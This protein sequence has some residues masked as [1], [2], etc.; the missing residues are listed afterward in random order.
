MEMNAID[1]VWIYIPK[2]SGLASIERLHRHSVRF[3]KVQFAAFLALLYF[4]LLNKKKFFIY[5]YYKFILLVSI[6]SHT[7]S[8]GPKFGLTRGLTAQNLVSQKW[9]HGQTFSSAFRNFFLVF[10]NDLFFVPFEECFPLINLLL[11]MTFKR[12]QRV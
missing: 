4:F 1:H 12:L 5:F 10:G 2:T 9:S 11:I 8:H 6:W 3:A 7:W